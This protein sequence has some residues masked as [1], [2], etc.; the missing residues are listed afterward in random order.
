MEEE[1]EEEG[2]EMGS[3]V[4]V[5][6]VMVGV[7]GGGG[8]R[9][10]EEVVSGGLEPPGIGMES[11][12]FSKTTRKNVETIKNCIY[13]RLKYVCTGLYTQTHTHTQTRKQGLQH[14]HTTEF[15]A[16]QCLYRDSYTPCTLLF[17]SLPQT[18]NT[19]THT[20]THH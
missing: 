1:E 15:M 13:I 7:V 3:V 10:G 16:H 18:Y 14:V 12:F 2:E 9:E 17:P 8:R 6:V 5:L 19:I 4:E 11:V 20:Y